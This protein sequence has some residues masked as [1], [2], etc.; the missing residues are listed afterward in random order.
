MLKYLKIIF[1]DSYS[2][3]FNLF[4]IIFISFSLFGFNFYKNILFD[5][6]LITV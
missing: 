2:V 1:C 6:F 5:D 3:F 4:L